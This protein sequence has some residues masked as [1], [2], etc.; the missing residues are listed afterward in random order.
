VGVASLDQRWATT[1]K[2]RKVT[3]SSATLPEASRQ[4]FF[5]RFS[6]LPDLT[7]LPDLTPSVTVWNS[8][9]ISFL[10]FPLIWDSAKCVVLPPCWFVPC[11]LKPLHRAREGDCDIAR[12]NFHN[13]IFCETHRNL[14]RISRRASLGWQLTVHIVV[15]RHQGH[16]GRSRDS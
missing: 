5:C 8:S 4:L 7:G 2:S 1:T 14:S 11:H 10:H 16:H 15:G 13:R 6:N 12:V 9:R 3:K